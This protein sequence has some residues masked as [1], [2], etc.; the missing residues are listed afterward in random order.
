MFDK[1]SF[2]E[3]RFSDLE[4]KISDPEVIADQALWRTLCKEHADIAPIVKKYQEY[5][6]VQ[7]DME[8]AKELLSESDKE[9]REMAEADLSEGRER[10][11]LFSYFSVIRN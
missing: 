1:L 8:G 4:K 2:I 3:E 9:L 10:I 6:K 5:K 7:S 11:G